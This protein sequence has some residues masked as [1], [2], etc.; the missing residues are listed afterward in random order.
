MV[1]TMTN[2][3]V[4]IMQLYKWLGFGELS[5]TSEGK[6]LSGLTESAFRYHPS[7]LRK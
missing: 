4:S 5:T 6:V 3:K 1:K 2:R 7:I